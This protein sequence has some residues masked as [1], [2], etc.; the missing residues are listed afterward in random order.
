MYLLNSSL[1]E[2]WQKHWLIK[3]LTHKI[4]SFNCTCTASWP[5]DVLHS[6]PG[7]HRMFI[8]IT[9]TEKSS[10]ADQ[11][12]TDLWREKQQAQSHESLFQSE[13]MTLVTLQI[14][15]CDWCSSETHTCHVTEDVQQMYDLSRF[16]CQLQWKHSSAFWDTCEWRQFK[17]FEVI[18]I[19]LILFRW[20]FF[21]DVIKEEI[22]T[23]VHFLYRVLIKLY[24]SVQKAVW[25]DFS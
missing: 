22:C 5:S 14:S 12:S 15:W 24:T 19:W 7:F 10:L 23:V 25:F 1:I 9:L 17:A 11:S 6:E 2:N 21:R 4:M 8:T 18:S 13:T 3:L 20:V 16:I